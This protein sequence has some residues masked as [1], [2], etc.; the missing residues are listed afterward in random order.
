MNKL[1]FGILVFSALPA[2]ANPYCRNDWDCT[3]GEM[4]QQ[5]ICERV[6]QPESS[7]PSQPQSEWM[8]RNDWDCADGESCV[9]GTCSS[10]SSGG[11]GD[12]P[13]YGG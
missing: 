1:V 5:G 10:S 8:C 2:L 3:D 12:D 6:T 9:A 4:C 7:T 13:I 11:G